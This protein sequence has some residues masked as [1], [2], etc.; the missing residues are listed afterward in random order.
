[1]T[2]A[3]RVHNKIG[4]R[5]V[6]EERASQILLIKPRHEYLRCCPGQ[7]LVSSGADR[8]PL[9]PKLWIAHLDCKPVKH[10]EV[11]SAQVEVVRGVLMQV[12]HPTSSVAQHAV[13]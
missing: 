3:Y 12:P 4:C 10:E 11:G 7:I 5:W 8:R 6:G 9:S 13:L 2:E 1:M